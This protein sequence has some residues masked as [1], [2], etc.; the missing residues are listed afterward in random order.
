MTNSQE[1]KYMDKDEIHL[2]MNDLVTELEECIKIATRALRQCDCYE[3]LTLV[4][5][6]RESYDF[7]RILLE[8]DELD[9]QQVMTNALIE[10]AIEYKMEV[11]NAET[12]QDTED[13][14]ASQTYSQD[15]EQ[16]GF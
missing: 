13:T 9:R 14:Q 6:A 8:G 16:V 1:S 15:S 10:N 11:A 3:A 7:I 2:M 5:L 12:D 4:R